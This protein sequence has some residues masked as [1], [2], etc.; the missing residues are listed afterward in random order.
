MNEPLNTA[1]PQNETYSDS[2][3]NAS[4][5][6]HGKPQPSPAVAATRMFIFFAIPLALMFIILVAAFAW[7]LNQG[8]SKAPV[9]VAATAPAKDAQIAQL[10]SEIIRLQ[11]RLATPAT[12]P[13]TAP[14]VT[15]PVPAYTDPTL[16]AQLSQRLDRLE[17]NQ[18]ALARA[19][20]AAEVSMR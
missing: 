5:M 7:K 3:L 16:L 4:D 19:A 10:Q 11:S 14:A 13:E 17:A 15:A 2:G 12:A 20:A 9:P 6:S 8:G 18:H 1:A